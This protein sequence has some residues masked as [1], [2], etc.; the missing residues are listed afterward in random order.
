MKKITL[1][2]LIAFSLVIASCGSDD[3]ND[4]VA[5]G[6]NNGDCFASWTVDGADYVEEELAL[7]VYMDNLFNLSSSF[8]GGIFQIQVDPITSPRAYVADPQNQELFVYVSVKL[9]DE[10]TL[11]SDNVIVEVE[12]IS[13]SK[14]KGTFSGDFFD[15]MDINQTPSFN[16]TNGKFEANF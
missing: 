6:P 15:L 3:D 13:N 7:C 11:V 8:S 5:A 9:D 4:G 2:L 1:F 12:E 10:T 16:V 14:A